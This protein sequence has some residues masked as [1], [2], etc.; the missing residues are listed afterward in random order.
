MVRT[1]S[2]TGR[3]KLEP[4]NVEIVGSVRH[5]DLRHDPRVIDQVV[6]W[7]VPP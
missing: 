1:T 2:G 3:S 7:L 5:S 6:G 4:R